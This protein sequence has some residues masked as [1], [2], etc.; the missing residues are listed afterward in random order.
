M[1]GFTPDNID[2]YKLALVHRSA[3]IR[4]EDGN[5]VNNERLEFLG[6]AVLECV[7]SDYL[8]IEYPGEPEGF[9]TRMRSRLVSRA[10][11]NELAKTIGLDRYVISN[12]G[13][14][15]IQKH[16]HGNAFEAVIGAIYL[17]KGYNFV[18]RMLIN[19]IF[20]KYVDLGDMSHTET[21]YK[22]RLIEWC[23]K[24]RRTIR[25]DTTVCDHTD[26][27][28]PKFLSHVFIDSINVSAG[29]GLSKKEAEQS[30]S[31]TAMKV[32]S[33]EVGYYILDKI[34]NLKNGNE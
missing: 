4:L 20:R 27:N 34:D 8:F 16:L 26:L 5:V 22:S 12:P 32:M 1:L 10:S 24:S 30:A 21:D 11:M 15:F 2:L 33:D 28:A 23:Q 25:F 13:G 18:N 3:S 17:D 31:L 9:L 29:E 14:S 6:D 19:D 7:V